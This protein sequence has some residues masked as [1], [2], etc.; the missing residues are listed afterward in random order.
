MTRSQGA[1]LPANACFPGIAADSGGCTAQGCGSISL[2][3]VIRNG[4]IPSGSQNR[5]ETRLLSDSP[6]GR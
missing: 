3:K 5:A 4:T 1:S 6:A 2:H